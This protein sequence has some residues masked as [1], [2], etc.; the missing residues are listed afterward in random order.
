MSCCSAP[1]SRTGRILMAVLYLLP[2]VLFTDSA[3]HYPGHAT[4]AVLTRWMAAV[5]WWL[6]AVFWIWRLFRPA[7]PSCR[8]DPA[9]S[10]APHE[11]KN[12]SNPDDP[13]S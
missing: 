1:T 12:E 7:R 3:L 9:L 4:S 11:A 8:P 10:V 2:A 6:I 5:I 13:A